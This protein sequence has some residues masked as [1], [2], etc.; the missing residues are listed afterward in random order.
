MLEKNIIPMEAIAGILLAINVL[1]P[2]SWLACIDRWLITRLSRTNTPRGR[3]RKSN[4][5][6]A[7]GISFCILF[8][9]VIYGIIIFLKSDGGQITSA[10]ISI[11]L[12]SAGIILGILSVI[13][14][15]WLH[16]T[17]SWL[18][19]S[20]PV[21]FVSL[22]SIILGIIFMLLAIFALKNNLYLLSIVMTYSSV[23]ILSGLWIALVPAIRSYLSFKSGVLIR[24]GLI[25]FLIAKFMQLS[26]IS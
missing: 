8:G 14:L 12:L 26:Q 20:H 6:I 15:V 21:L 5:M 10:I 2:R 22:V 24:I 16:S 4:W 17:Y 7:L 11:T 13:F 19:Q 9:L 1:I 23:L 18:R 25:I 3:L